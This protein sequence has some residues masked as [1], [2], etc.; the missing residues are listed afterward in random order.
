MKKI[1]IGVAVLSIVIG[2]F[3]GPGYYFYYTLFSGQQVGK[4]QVTERASTW[5]L[6]GGITMRFGVT[7][8][9]K[10]FGVNL[11]PQMN[12]V[13]LIWH[14]LVDDH[15]IGA[16]KVRQNR[17]M[18]SMY[19]DQQL[20]LKES[21]QIVRNKE[22]GKKSGGIKD[23]WKTIGTLDVPRAGQYHFVIEEMAKPELRVS[24]ISIEVRRNIEF[25]DMR[26]VWPGTALLATAFLGILIALFG[27]FRKTA[28]PKITV[29][30]KGTQWLSMEMTAAAAEQIFQDFNAT[31]NAAKKAGVFI[32]DE[33]DLPHP[34]KRIKEAILFALRLTSDPKMREE[35][36]SAYLS[37]A[38]WQAGIGEAK[39]PGS[40]SMLKMLLSK[41]NDLRKSADSSGAERK[42][43]Q[44]ELLKSGL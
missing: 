35:L 23:E 15:V 34:K 21:M 33:R 4:Y 27:N 39:K 36:K 41:E 13:R 42:I 3:A 38:A 5:S 24:D 25:P 44:A 40:L 30:P 7:G 19:L 16:D 29:G 20:L 1:M 8:G 6:P 18:V 11:D 14:A 32:A 2:L 31:L 28:S 22:V 17:Y 26:I 12:P 37:L 10:P 43:L 9:Y